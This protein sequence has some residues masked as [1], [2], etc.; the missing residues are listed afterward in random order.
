MGSVKKSAQAKKDFKVVGHVL[1]RTPRIPTRGD[2]NDGE[3]VEAVGIHAMI[4][5]TKRSMVSNR[6]TSAVYPMTDPCLEYLPLFTIKSTQLNVGKYTI[7]GSY[8][9]WG[10]NPFC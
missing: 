7:H 8:G 2:R 9:Y 5:G 1:S 6:V 10:C 3:A 4:N